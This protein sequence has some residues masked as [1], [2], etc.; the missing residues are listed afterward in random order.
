MSIEV[1]ALISVVKT[2]IDYAKGAAA[3]QNDVG[4]L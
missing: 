3:F 1:G 2:T 4:N